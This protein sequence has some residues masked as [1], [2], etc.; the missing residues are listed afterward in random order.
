MPEENGGEGGS[1]VRK[2][3]TTP[4]KVTPVKSPDPKKHKHGQEMDD[5]SHPRRLEFETGTPEA[6]IATCFKSLGSIVRFFI[7]KNIY[8][9]ID[10][11]CI[12]NIYINMFILNC[13][14]SGW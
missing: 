8:I 9:Y 6:P 3:Q 2:T 10:L 4:V 1:R 7:K 11:S 5:D 12:D 14:F 13:H